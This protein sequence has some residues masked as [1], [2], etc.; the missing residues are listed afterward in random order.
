MAL[1]EKAKNA[2][3]EYKKN[4]GS[5]RKLATLLKVNA[6]YIS[7][8]LN[9]WGDYDLSNESKNE[10]E[11]KISDF[12]SSKQLK[13]SSQYDEICEDSDIVPFRNTVVIIASVIKA[14]KQRALMKIVGKSG[15]GKTTAINAL[16]KKLPQSIVITAFAGM[17]KKDL[18]ESIAF[19]L[20]VMPKRTGI[21][22]LIEAIKDGLSGGNRVLIIDEANFIS[23]VS[24]EQIRY[25]Q[26]MTK[27]PIIL[28][29]TENLEK[30]IAKSH[31]QVATR[32]RNTH[33]A[34][35]VFG[36]DEVEMLFEKENIK[37]DKKTADKV[38]KRC[39]NLREVKYALDD[40]NEIYKGDIA[41]IDAV[42]PRSYYE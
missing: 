33:E 22:H 40:L 20:G 2:L 25:L 15:T 11:K 35:R 23:T 6:S 7:L 32:I 27:T 1:S 12:F 38:W 18:L 8:A 34:L 24:L 28:V 10:I 5:Y 39:K 42:L 9:G 16:S 26:D 30:E 14:I 21:S 17:N 31:E 3:N 4:G 19:K 13:I 41:K 36:E 29:G 37:I